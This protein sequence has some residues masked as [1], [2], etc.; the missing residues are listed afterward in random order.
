[1]SSAGRPRCG[2]AL[3]QDGGPVAFRRPQERRHV[4]RL[5]TTM[6]TTGEASRGWLRVLIAVTVAATLSMEPVFMLGAA[7]PAVRSD[8]HFDARHLGVSVSAFWVAMALAGLVSGRLAQA[9][10]PRRTI[11][12]GVSAAVASLVGMLAAPSW[13]VLLA[14]ACLGGIG[15]ALTT[16]AGDMALFSVTPVR[17]L[18][19]AYGVKQ[20]ALPAASFLAGVGV[21]ALVLTLGWRWAFGAGALLAVPALLVLPRRLAARAPAARRSTKRASLH[22]VVPI[23]VAVALAMSAVSATGGFFVESAVTKGL[24]GQQ[25]GTLLAIG[26]GFGI[27]GRFLFSWKLGRIARPLN[28]VALL[29]A[30]GGAG[31]A[32]FTVSGR[33]VLLVLA[34]VLAFGAGWGWNG[35]LTQ[36]VVSSHPDDTARASAYIMVGAAVGGVVGPA[37]F[38]LVAD[39]VGISWAWAGAAGALFAGAVVLLA[40]GVRQGAGQ[41]APHGADEERVQIASEPS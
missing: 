12:T 31:V 17:R 34:T 33:P 28:L 6:V 4:V 23:A 19:V 11:V 1:M 21:P 5:H 27:A 30:L 24:S 37:S 32:G 38:G 8:L 15:A 26:S 40:L 35:L 7:A 41:L 2:W 10:G 29:L 9:W 16:P 3:V 14:G 36:T 13:W 22:D 18:G 20:A 39:A 25:A